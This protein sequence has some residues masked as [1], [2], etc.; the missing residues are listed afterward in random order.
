MCI[1]G[2]PM[3]VGSHV[4]R[5]SLQ[6]GAFTSGP[7][8]GWNQGGAVPVGI[9]IAPPYGVRGQHDNDDPGPGQWPLRMGCDLH[10]GRVG[11][12]SPT[13]REDLCREVMLHTHW[14]PRRS[15]AWE[16]KCIS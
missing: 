7:F 14:I 8:W 9:F 16:K 13:Q 2:D 15:C 4:S 3:A 6:V 5:E 1:A 10:L 11:I 12:A